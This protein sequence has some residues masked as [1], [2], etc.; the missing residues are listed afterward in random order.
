[1]ATLSKKP[2]HWAL[3]FDHWVKD[4]IDDRDVTSLF[5]FE[6][7]GKVARLAVPTTDHYIPLLYSLAL[8]EEDDPITY[9]YEEVFSGISM[10]CLRIG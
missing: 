1:M 5:Q 10:R 4:R 2:F 9:T 6:K 7:L 3:E 8:A